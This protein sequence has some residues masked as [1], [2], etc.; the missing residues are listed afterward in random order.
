M[1]ASARTPGRVIAET[2][3]N[4]AV[5]CLVHGSTQGPGGWDFLSAQL[6]QRGHRVITPGIPLDDADAD[7]A[8]CARSIIDAL[9]EH[10]AGTIADV[11]VVAHSISGLFLPLVAGNARVAQLVYLAAAVPKPGSSFREQFDATPDMYNP[12]WIAAGRRIASDDREAI[13]FLYHDCSPAVI[14]RALAERIEFRATRLWSERFALTAQPAI[15]TRYVVCSLDRTFTPAWMRR[16]ARQ[17]LGIAPLE[18]SAG[19]CPYLSQPR[20]LAEMLIEESRTI[21]RQNV[22]RDPRDRSVG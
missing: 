20:Q 10:P 21:V 13:R 18:L 17:T 1:P 8:A 4:A 11:T 9:S 2:A 7:A 3:N 6:R 12:E 14:R 16:T 22:V 5:F 19:H 15:S